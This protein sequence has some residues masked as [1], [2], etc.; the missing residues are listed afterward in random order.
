MN[1]REKRNLYVFLNNR[2]FDGYDE[3]L[4]IAVE[5][6]EMRQ[7]FGHEEED[8]GGLPLRDENVPQQKKKKRD[9]RDESLMRKRRIRACKEEE[10]INEEEADADRQNPASDTETGEEEEAEAEEDEMK[11]EH[12][13]A[14]SASGH[15][16]AQQFN[17]RIFNVTVPT[18][19]GRHKLTR[20]DVAKRSIIT[21][22]NSDNLCFPR[23]LVVVRIYCERGNLRTEELHEKLNAVRYRQSMLQRELALELTR[24]AGVTIPE[25]GCGLREIERFQ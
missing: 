8:A 21:I 23:S 9:A 6:I 20:K 1:G 5:I 24:N 18:D 11:E 14:Q 25:E 16:I 22:R 7:A 15:D 19:R 3:L 17:I 12:S 4:H 13:V 2:H 10:E